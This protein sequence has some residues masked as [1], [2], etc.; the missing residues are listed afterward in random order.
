MIMNEKMILMG[1]I[2]T[3]LRYLVGGTDINGFKIKSA[4]IISAG[5]IVA[6]LKKLLDKYDN[7]IVDETINRQD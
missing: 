7:L 2:A 6:K 1:Q 3:H 5:P 4:D